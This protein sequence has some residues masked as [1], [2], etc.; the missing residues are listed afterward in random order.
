MFKVAAALQCDAG[1]KRRLEDLVR[2]GKTPQKV[3]QRANIILLAASGMSNNRIAKAVKTTRPTVLVWRA[4][5]EQFGCPGLLKDF[6]RPGR[7]PLESAHVG[8]EDGTVA[9]GRST[10]LEAPRAAASSGGDLQ[11][12][13]RQTVYRKASGYCRVVP[14]AARTGLGAV[15]G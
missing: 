3:V 7:K 9:C 4:R 2:A 6:Q 12:L 15:R 5:F 10:H 13:H 11:N 8:E 1:Q 14:E